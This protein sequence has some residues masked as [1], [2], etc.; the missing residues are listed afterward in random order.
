[1]I[2]LKDITDLNPYCKVWVANIQDYD[3]V[4]MINNTDKYIITDMDVSEDRLNVLVRHD[5][6]ILEP[7][8]L[9]IPPK[10][11]SAER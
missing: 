2:T 6:A 5:D 4:D 10:C 11:K 7:N 8:H 3:V 9:F 1:M